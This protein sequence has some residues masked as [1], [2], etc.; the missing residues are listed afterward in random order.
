MNSEIRPPIDA[1]LE[2]CVAGA[3]VPHAPVLLP[4]VSGDPNAGRTAEVRAAIAGLE[5]ED[6]D[7]IVLLSPHG[8]ETGVYRTTAGSLEAFGLPGIRA[9]HPTDDETVE[10]LSSTWRRPILD[11]RVDH[12]VLVPLLCMCPSVPVVATS[13]EETRSFDRASMEESAAEGR[14]FA[15]ALSTMRGVRFAFVA[16][17]NT[18]AGLNARAPLTEVKEAVEVEERLV[19]DLGRG[20]LSGALAVELGV[21]GSCAAGTLAAFAAAFEGTDIRLRAHDA[22]F[23]VGYL[24]ATAERGN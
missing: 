15:E 1:R 2:G 19:G 7:A 4:A 9:T 13:L 8:Q 5:F 24:V 22:P 23:G 21:A 12:G 10:R 6:I 20:G 11:G 14:C 17:C 18:S 3:I 16:S